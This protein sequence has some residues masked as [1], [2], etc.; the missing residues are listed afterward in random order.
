MEANAGS[1]RCTA[2]SSEY[3][4]EGRCLIDAL[5]L[6]GYRKSTTVGCPLRRGLTECFRS[7]PE[8]TSDSPVNKP[9]VKMDPVPPVLTTA[10]PNNR[11]DALKCLKQHLF[12]INALDLAVDRRIATTVGPQL[13][14]LRENAASF[15][16]SAELS[17]HSPVYGLVK[18]VPPVATEIQPNPVR[19]DRRRSLWKRSK[20]F[21][22]KSM[23]N[24]GRRICFCQTF[25]D[26]E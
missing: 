16:S 11:T 8:L 9:V 1:S 15:R 10:D 19:S 17:I 12:V 21:M 5:D 18:S 22:W 14:P 3:A 4:D 25:V 6:A 2:Q 20:R 23:V 13:R 7:T 24:A 26:L